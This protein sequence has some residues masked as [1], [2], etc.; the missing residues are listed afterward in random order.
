MFSSYW[1]QQYTVI[2]PLV[3][4]LAV[5]FLL[6]PYSYSPSDRP[7]VPPDHVR[8]QPLCPTV[9]GP[10]VKQLQL[11]CHWL[12][13]C[14]RSIVLTLYLD[15]GGSPGRGTSATLALIFLLSETR[16]SACVVPARNLLISYISIV[17]IA[18]RYTEIIAPYCI[19][20][21]LLLLTSIHCI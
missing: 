6:V 18:Y 10:I 14:L 16:R 20:V 3:F 17:A 13:V 8:D 12:I 1:L 11:L 4:G 9:Q 19:I 2:C 5:S 21:T 7:A 15:K